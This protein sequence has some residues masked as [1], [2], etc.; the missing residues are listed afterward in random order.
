MQWKTDFQITDTFLTL[1]NIL[2]VYTMQKKIQLIRIQE[3]K[4]IDIVYFT[5]LHPI[6]PSM[7]LTFAVLTVLA[8]VFSMVW[9]KIVI[10]RSLVE[11]HGISHLSLLSTRYV[12]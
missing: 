8:T 5:V 9:Y 3:I 6:F 4:A 10:Q 7:S 12:L 11:Y 1:S 2:N